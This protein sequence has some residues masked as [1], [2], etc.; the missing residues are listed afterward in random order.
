MARD[1]GGN[2]PIHIAAQYGNAKCLSKLINWKCN[3]ACFKD[4][5][6]NQ[7]LQKNS[8]GETALALA[9]RFDKV[10]CIKILIKAHG[11]NF[12]KLICVYFNGFSI[13]TLSVAS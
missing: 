6:K 5:M 2:T 13:F 10:N 12:N 11:F 1:I 4:A 9:I 3:H 8:N 7:L